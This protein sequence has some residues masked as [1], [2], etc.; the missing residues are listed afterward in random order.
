MPAL[1]WLIGQTANLLQCITFAYYCGLFLVGLPIFLPRIGAFLTAARSG[2]AVWSA[3]VQRWFTRLF[4]AA[5]TDCAAWSANACRWFTHLFSAAHTDCAAWSADACRWFTRLF[6]AAHT[7]CAAWSADACR[8][9]TRLFSAA[10]TDCAAW[11]A[12]AQH[13]FSLPFSAVRANWVAWLTATQRASTEVLPGNYPLW[14]A[15][16]RRLFG[17]GHFNGLR[18]IGQASVE[19]ISYCFEKICDIGRR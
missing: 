1:W 15:G 19:G 2:W 8:W 7:D 11:S 9:F 16:F 18:S 4:S 13:W 6:S 5:H 17:G 14:F 12:D 3:D 10:H